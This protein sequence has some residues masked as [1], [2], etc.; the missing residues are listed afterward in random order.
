[1]KPVIAIVGAGAIGCYYGGRLAQHGHEVHFLFRSGYDAVAKN[2][3]IVSSPDGDFSIAPNQLH[4]HRRAADVPKAD[5]V[6]VTLKTTAND[7]FQPLISPL[8]KDDTLILTLQNGLGNEERLAELFGAERVLGGLAFVCVNRMPDGSIRHMDHGQIKLGEF[9]GGPRERTR[10]LAR[11]FSESRVDCRVLDDLRFGRWEKLVWN[12]PFN[13]LGALLGM[14]T[15]KLIGSKAGVEMV[16]RLMREVIHAAGGLGVKL[17]PD[18]PEL[19]IA[20]TRTMGA[21]RTSMQIDR[22][23]GRPLEVESILGR[24]LLAAQ[25][26][27][28]ATPYMQMLYDLLCLG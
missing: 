26:A 17:P 10:E 13:G 20:H 6:I 22:E 18:L 1:M 28:V 11:L 2:G 7:Q 19:K 15:D 25:G 14:T 9:A 4:I 3:L 5:I 27:G 24:P 16:T 8:L 21:Y 23:E 12:V